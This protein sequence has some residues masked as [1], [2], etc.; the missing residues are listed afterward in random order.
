MLDQLTNFQLSQLNN[1]G[2][3]VSMGHETLNTITCTPQGS[4]DDGKDPD[5]D[6]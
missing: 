5:A 3:L 2:N 4:K 6:S 1:A